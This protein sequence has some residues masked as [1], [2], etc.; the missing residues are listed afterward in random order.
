M[1]KT[2]RI[3][4]PLG[5]LF[6]GASDK[7][8]CFLEFADSHS[9]DEQ[10][11]ETA[12]AFN[13]R[14]EESSNAHLEELA[15]QLKDYFSGNRTRF[16]L[17]LDI[18]GTRFQKQAWKVLMDIPYG[19]T[20]SYKEQATAAGRPTAVRAVANANHANRIGIIIPCHRVIGSDGSLTGYGGGLWRK[21]FLLN[22]ESK[23][24][25]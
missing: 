25:R 14:V 4:S 7:G 19:T 22:L 8:I 18:R 21:E 9:K 16:D 5:V 15:L 10:I 23:C 17:S 6:T 24:S 20:I 13:A 12:K 1:I 11:I 3:S 2:T